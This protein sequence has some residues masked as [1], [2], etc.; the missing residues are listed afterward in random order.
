M[1]RMSGMGVEV[2]IDLVIDD[3]WSLYDEDKNGTLEYNE[4]KKFVKDALAM[5]CRSSC[6]DE[7]IFQVLFQRFDV[8]GN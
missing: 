8:D 3:M 5:M 7:G 6:Y 1:L 2:A 4:V